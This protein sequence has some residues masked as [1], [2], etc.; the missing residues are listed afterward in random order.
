MKRRLLQESA[1][2]RVRGLA[3]DERIQ[4]NGVL[5]TLGGSAHHIVSYVQIKNS[6]NSRIGY[7]RRHIW[8]RDGI[9]PRNRSEYEKDEDGR[10]EERSPVKEQSQQPCSGLS[11]GSFHDI[12]LG[13]L[14]C[15]HQSK[16]A[17]SNH[18]HL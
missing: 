15:E 14:N 18:V 3:K 8:C 10:N 6:V 9:D 16:R 7:D 13:R 2:E 1:I 17:R 12:H 4:S 11:R 5:Q